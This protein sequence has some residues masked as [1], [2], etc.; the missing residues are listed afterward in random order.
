MGCVSCLCKPVML[1]VWPN[2][3]R[4]MQVVFNSLSL[5]DALAP[6]NLELQSGPGSGYSAIILRNLTVQADKCYDQSWLA[7]MQ[8]LVGMQQ[9]CA[10]RP[11]AC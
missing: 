5:L 9:V 6:Y 3:S 2:C 7:A 11:D 8:L 10:A 1:P 4:C